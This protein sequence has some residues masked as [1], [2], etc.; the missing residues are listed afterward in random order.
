MRVHQYVKNSLVLL[1]V[2]TSHQFTYKAILSA[3]VAFAAFSLCA[4][5]V[6]VFNDLLDIDSDR[7][8]PSKKHRPIA[9]GAISPLHGKLAIPCLLALSF[10][11][12]AFVSI[13]F[14][15]VLLA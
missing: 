12:A 14:L 13:T 11:S 4:S 10:L 15:L 3:L 5:A 1:P 7:Q 8:H 9:S 2:I 6:Y